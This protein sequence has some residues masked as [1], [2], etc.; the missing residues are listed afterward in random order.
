KVMSSK[1]TASKAMRGSRHPVSPSNRNPCGS[2]GSTGCRQTSM[3]STVLFG[4]CLRHRNY[5][6][7]GAVFRFG[8]VLNAAINQSKQ[9]VVFT[10]PT[11]FAGMLFAAAL[12]Q[13]R[14]AGEPGPTPKNLHAEP[15]T[16]R[17]APVP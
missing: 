11:F 6:Y 7:E 1:A 3:W 10:A 5:R 14:V 12:A 17:V 9:G 8:V 2:A 15:L 13:E 4:R 16:R